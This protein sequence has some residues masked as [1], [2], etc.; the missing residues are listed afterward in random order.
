SSAGQD[1]RVRLH[2]HIGLRSEA[3]GKLVAVAALWT[4]VDGVSFGMYNVVTLPE[5]RR[6]GFARVLV[7]VLLARADK[8][9][10]R[11]YLQ[12]DPKND[13]AVRLY[14][15]E[16][17]GKTET[18]IMDPVTG[19]PP[20]GTQAMLRIRGASHH[21]PYLSALEAAMSVLGPGESL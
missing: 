17:F 16:R 3:D 15:S 21:D 4:L 2:H 14:E 20:E 19:R 11:V 6:N 8:G 7:Q 10:Q 1:I 12:V 9:G 13:G 18:R 5:F